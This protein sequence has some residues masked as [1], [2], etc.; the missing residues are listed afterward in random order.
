MRWKR[1][2][3]FGSRLQTVP[4]PLNHSPQK[5]L[6]GKGGR[7]INTWILRL[8]TVIGPWRRQKHGIVVGA[9]TTKQCNRQDGSSDRDGRAAVVSDPR[10]A[11][12]HPRPEMQSDLRVV[13]VEIIEHKMPHVEALEEV[14]SMAPLRAVQY[15]SLEVW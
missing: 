14:L 1:N 12:R 13:A 10:V 11:I 8:H 6:L 3:L 4:F 5:V 15:A 2:S 7:G 9:T